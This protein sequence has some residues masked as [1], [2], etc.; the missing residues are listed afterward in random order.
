[1][2]H[3]VQVDRA[4]VPEGGGKMMLDVPGDVTAGEELESAIG[5]KQ[6][7]AAGAASR[8]RSGPTRPRA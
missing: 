1:M 4:E 2:G 6:G 3:L 8:C 5:E 7:D